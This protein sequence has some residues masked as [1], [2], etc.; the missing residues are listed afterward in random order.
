VIRTVAGAWKRSD[1]GRGGWRW[2]WRW[3]RFRRLAGVPVADEPVAAEEVLVVAELALVEAETGRVVANGLET[4]Q[5]WA[6]A[7]VRDHL[8]GITREAA[9]RLTRAPVAFRACAAVIIALA[10][11]AFDAARHRAESAGANE[12]VAAI[13]ADF[14]DGA[15]SLAGD[16]AGSTV[17]NEGVAAIVAGFAISSDLTAGDRGAETF[18]A[19]Q[20]VATWAVTLVAARVSLAR[21]CSVAVS[22]VAEEIDAAFLGVGADSAFFEAEV[23]ASADF[24]FAGKPV[25]ASCAFAAAGCSFSTTWRGTDQ[26]RAEQTVAAILSDC[27]LAT[28]DLAFAADRNANAGFT[29]KTIGAVVNGFT[30]LLGESLYRSFS[31][32][33]NAKPGR[34]P[35]QHAPA[36]SSSPELPGKVIES[37]TIHC[38]PPVQLRTLRPRPFLIWGSKRLSAG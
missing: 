5:T 12:A 30:G 2:R 18:D 25:A 24:I 14:A 9:G 31:D 15:F 29:C 23:N 11:F 36:R 3:V 19:F 21:A 7:V 22:E 27:A 34:E 32:K 6:A 26:A 20:G 28:F 1:G 33:R 8:A 4:G 37:T 13:V 10:G 38:T 16:E 35:L 17:A